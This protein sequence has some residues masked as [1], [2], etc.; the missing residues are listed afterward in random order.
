MPM[1]G[2]VGCDVTN[3]TLIYLSKSQQVPAKGRLERIPLFTLA[4]RSTS[5]VSSSSFPCLVPTRSSMLPS[6]CAFRTRI[7]HSL[8]LPVPTSLFLIK[9]SK[10]CIAPGDIRVLSFCHSGNIRCARA[11]AARF[12]YGSRNAGHIK[13]T[14][15]NFRREDCTI[16]R[17]VPP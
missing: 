4:K 16:L 15:A 8:Q 11:F 7:Y 14:T 5:H 17:T 6:P 10:R 3:D 12:D 13:D 1:V 2:I 9:A